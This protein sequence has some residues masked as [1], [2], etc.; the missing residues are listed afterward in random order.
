MRSSILYDRWY[1][2]DDEGAKAL[3]EALERMLMFKAWL[4]D[5]LRRV[6]SHHESRRLS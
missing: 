4:T 6:L 3:N 1:H 2:V 5:F